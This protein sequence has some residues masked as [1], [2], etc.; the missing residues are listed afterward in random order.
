MNKKLL[1]VLIPILTIVLLILW[2]IQYVNSEEKPFQPKIE[3]IH[4]EGSTQGTTYSATYQQPE[5]LDLQAKIEE[6]LHQFDTSLST[7]IPNSIISRI[8]RNDE[9]VTTDLDFETMFNT[10]Q[11]TA[12][13]TNGA[14]DITVGPLVKAWGF[15]F[16]N[17]NH[18]K[19]PDVS[20]YLPYVGY[21]KVR[22]VNHKLIKDDPRIIIDA[23][24]VAQ[25]YSSDIIAK[26]LESNGCKNYMIEIGGEVACKGLNPTNSKWRIGI[27]KAIDDTTNA[28]NGL[29]AVV[30]MSG[31][32]LTTA[33][34]YRKFYI[35]D[36]KKYAHII[37]PHTGMPV[38]HNL[39]SA[40]VIAPTALLADAY[41][42][43]FMVIG[44]DSSLAVCKR[45][46][47]LEC[48]LIY[49]DEKGENKVVYT[50]GF[51]KYL[52]K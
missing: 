9:S 17:K 42:T 7:Y 1:Y 28:N 38:N 8:N 47:G 29:Q 10:A 16:G 24:A 45:I 39:L 5:G 19:L 14:L 30:E 37:N 33:G 52:A 34:N 18:D 25:G 40:T 20:K 31:G 27:D 46:P 41:D 35:K 22:I 44:I 11:E 21:K 32:G 50:P 2:L 51:K 6:R 12:R 48:Y 43:A 3:Y 36:G 15:A 23:N 13:Q 4:N 26:L 49:V